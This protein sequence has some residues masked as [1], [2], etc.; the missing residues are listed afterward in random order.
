MYNRPVTLLLAAALQAVVALL[1]VFE[2]GT[3]VLRTVAGEVADPS[4]AY[5]LAVF[6]LVVAGVLGFVAWGLVMLRPWA[7]TPV[8]LTQIFMLI[9]AYS[10]YEA[11]RM[12]VSVGMVAVAVAA[13]GLVLA[14]ATTAVLFPG[15]NTDGH[16]AQSGRSGRS[17]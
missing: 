1:V 6:G 15:E 7:R 4:F 17:G 2:S 12:S 14:P 9:V 5:P 8:V 11:D 16:G 13:I 3:L 10:M